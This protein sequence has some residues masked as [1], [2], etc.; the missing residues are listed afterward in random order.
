MPADS[1]PYRITLASIGVV[2]AIEG[3]L[4]ALSTLGLLGAGEFQLT[5]VRAIVAGLD[6]LLAI[7]LLIFAGMVWPSGLAQRIREYCLRNPLHYF[8]ALALL[9]ILFVGG[10]AL[11]HIDEATFGRLVYYIASLRP[12]IRWIVLLSLQILFVLSLS[13]PDMLPAWGALWHDSPS[14]IAV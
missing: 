12:Q 8:L 6:V 2:S 11:Y 4:A 3:I 10:F 9:V 14:R 5:L 7:Y 13:L 1:K